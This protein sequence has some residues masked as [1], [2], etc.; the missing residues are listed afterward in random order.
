MSF[1]MAGISKPPTTSGFSPPQA[2]KA[3]ERISTRI[4][5]HVTFFDIVVSSFS[6][7]CSGLL[8]ADRHTSNTP[9]FALAVDRL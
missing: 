9:A 3:N 2:L 5:A 1:W 4:S 8:L 6:V 7:F